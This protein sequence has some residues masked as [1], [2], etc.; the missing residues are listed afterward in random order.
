MSKKQISML[1]LLLL[2]GLLVFAACGKEQDGQPPDSQGTARKGDYQLISQKEAK[3]RMDAGGVVVLDVRTMEEYAGAHIPGAKL[4]PNETLV[5][6][7]PAVLP[8]KAAAILVYCRSGRRSKEAAEKL[9]SLGYE[10]VYDFGGII[11]WP[12]GTE[13]GEQ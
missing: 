1:I 11:D 13:I 8:D 10:N 2:G 6:N 7:A 9:I 3:E 12:Y 5:A 4:L